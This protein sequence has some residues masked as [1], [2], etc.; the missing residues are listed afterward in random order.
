MAWETSSWMANTS[1]SSRSK[2]S[3]QSW[4][5]CARFTS[6][7][8]RPEPPP[9]P[10]HAALEHRADREPAADASRDV[11]VRA[12]E[13]EGGGARDHAQPLDLGQR[14]DQLVGH[15]VGEVLVLRVRAEVGEG[16]DR[17]R[18]RRARLRRRG[19]PLPGR[20]GGADAGRDQEVGHRVEAGY[21][22]A[23]QRAAQGLVQRRRHLRRCAAGW[24]HLGEAADELALG[25]SPL[26]GGSPASISN[27]VQASAKR[28]LRP[29]T[30]RSPRLAPGSC[31]WACPGSPGRR[32]AVGAGRVERPRDAEVGH[33]RVSSCSRM[34][35]GLMSRWTTP[36][37]WA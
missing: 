35:S 23:G 7:A 36:W 4:K 33:D 27:T 6:W 20:L 32:D 16:Q 2:V 15:S 10:A 11:V 3:D 34:F 22:L 13:G 12:L 5:P 1:S 9:G 25:V 31:R 8:L 17:D 24:G 21:R 19:R 28:S 37:R 29:S 18:P 14:V 30:A 26:K